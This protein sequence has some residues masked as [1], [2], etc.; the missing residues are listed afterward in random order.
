MAEQIFDHRSNHPLS[1]SEPKGTI[2]I[3]R[4]ID[5]R[6][7]RQL[8]RSTATSPHWRT[9]AVHRG[10]QRAG[11]GVDSTGTPGH[12]SQGTVRQDPNRPLALAHTRHERSVHH[13]R[14]PDV[15]G[16]NLVYTRNEEGGIHF[17]HPADFLHYNDI[18]FPCTPY[19]ALNQLEYWSAA[20]NRPGDIQSGRRNGGACVEVVERRTVAGTC[21]TPRT[22]H[23]SPALLHGRRVAGFPQSARAGEFDRL[24]RPFIRRPESHHYELDRPTSR[25]IPPR[26]RTIGSF[27]AR[28]SSSVP[29]A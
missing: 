19:S 28:L 4:S 21:G 13:A 7:A 18:L 2:S 11:R 15:D 3:R 23:R 22:G 12:S 24:R 27:P 14:V 17:E 16:I 10:C 25:V 9:S 26:E 8:R 1:T 5:F 6:Q 29:P 20:K